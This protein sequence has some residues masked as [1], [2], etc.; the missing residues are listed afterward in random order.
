MLK[1]RQ[2]AHALTLSRL[3]NFS[4]AAVASNLSQPAFSRSIR[5]LENDLGVSLFDR[6]GNN[7]VPTLY[8]EALLRWAEKIITDT[9]E[10]EREI[11]LTQGLEVGRFGVS[12]AQYPADLTGGRAISK[13][14]LEHPNLQI[15]VIQSDWRDVTGYVLSRDVDLG[16]AE[17]SVAERD[18]RLEV[19]L[20]GQ[21]RLIICCRTEHPLAKRKKVTRKDLDQYPLV[22]V[23]LPERLIR[24]PGKSYIDKES[25]LLI[26]S[27][28]SANLAIAKEIIS[29]SD[30]IGPLT[31]LQIE[32]ELSNK[33]LRILPFWEP[34]LHLRYG[35][36]ALRN[37]LK[38]PAAEL[39][40]ATVREME[41]E[42]RARN[43]QL[44]K[45][46]LPSF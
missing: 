39:F 7:V 1:N 15:N 40:M 21:H 17:V 45:R 42:V 13:M 8:G 36:I 46:F 22:A 43:Q 19:E 34:F 23:P 28:D 11:R 25:G 35:F 16:F 4:R 10:L 18:N 41:N 5:C 20:V 38:S 3:G 37:R 27:I 2:L 32:E 14:A 26:P 30:A 12:M 24:F 9:E 29:G 44:F 33:K 31:P 6:D